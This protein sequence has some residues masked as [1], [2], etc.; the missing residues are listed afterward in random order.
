MTMTFIP[1]PTALLGIH[2]PGDNFPVVFYA[3][4]FGMGAALACWLL[5]LPVTRILVT[6]QTTRLS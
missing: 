5:L 6:L 2:A 3:A 1:S 4:N